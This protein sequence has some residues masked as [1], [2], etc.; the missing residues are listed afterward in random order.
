MLSGV[1]KKGNIMVGIQ[2]KKSI[3][4]CGAQSKENRAT[5]RRRMIG[6]IWGSCLAGAVSHRVNNN[7][8]RRHLYSEYLPVL[9]EQ[10]Q[11]PI[12]RTFGEQLTDAV[13][14]VMDE[15]GLREKGV[16]F[17]NHNLDDMGNRHGIDTLPRF[18][19]NIQWP[20]RLQ[21][22]NPTERIRNFVRG[23][24]MFIMDNIAT[25]DT[26]LGWFSTKTNKVFSNLDADPIP[27]FHEIGHALDYNSSALKRF[28]LK[29]SCRMSRFLPPA[30]IAASLLASPKVLKNSK[31]EKEREIKQGCAI[32]GT[33]GAVALS[34]VPTLLL[35]KSA[36]NNA[37]KLINDHT[38]LKD[39]AFNAVRTVTRN[40]ERVQESIRL[41]LVQMIKERY[42]AAYST[43]KRNAIV[44]CATAVVGMAIKCLWDNY[45]LKQPKQ[46]SVL[47]N[48]IQNKPQI[49]KN[50][51]FSEFDKK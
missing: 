4:F 13:Y 46:E 25:P 9:R 17:V 39:C 2:S 48:N 42:D 27:A 26:H 50:S 35:E 15:S 19:E 31:N 41:P 18:V 29:Y 44:W 22:F 8:S 38:N 43:Y 1:L 30:I 51:V 3:S 37:M 36:T 7:L 45:H 20:E 12:V 24:D 28:F 10:S 32:L 6:N 47:H 49:D 40:G 14:S 11:F 34:Q 21:R 5:T 33:V 23:H 16:R